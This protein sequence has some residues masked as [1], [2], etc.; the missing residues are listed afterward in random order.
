V[1]GRLYLGADLGG[2]HFRV[3]IRREGEAALLAHEAI[4]SDPTWSLEGVVRACC[5][6]LRR[7]EERQGEVSLAAAGFGS[8]G[9]INYHTGHCYSMKRFPG[10][11]AAPLAAGLEQEL[12]RPVYLL[13][14]GL[15]AALAELRV[16]AGRGMQSFVMITLGTGI[17]G[18]IVMD[19]RLMA[20]PE[21]RVGKV[22][23]QI[24]DLDGPVH[25]HCGL[26]GC[27]QTLAGKEGILARARV[28]AEER[29][30]SGLAA[31]LRRDPAADL[32]AVSQLAASG[33]PPAVDLIRETGRY[34]GIGLAN[35]VKILAPERILIGGGVAEAN[36]LLLDAI[37]E[38]IDRYAIKPYQRVP[39]A[40]AGLGHHAGLIG[41]TLLAE[42]PLPARPGPDQPSG[43]PG[44]G[45]W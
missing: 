31:L 35:L 6:L 27:W 1:S 33:D 10:L 38:T 29:P 14:D 28:M 32:A 12:E 36:P 4:P 30:E 15:C 9:D 34:V 16:G 21:G 42:E 2:T 22:G 40:A 45:A 7:I 18:G 43:F 37:R 20:G 23:H 24:L 26:P 17:G 11:E 41:A 8:T 25:C 44:P 3:G 5:D 19:G 39:V 13:N